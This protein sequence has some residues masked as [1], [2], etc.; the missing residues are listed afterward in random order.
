MAVAVE[1]EIKGVQFSNCNCAYACPCQF[2]GYPDK[3]HCEAVGAYHVDQG[4]YGDVRLD[5]LTAVGIYKWPG[6]VHEGNGAMQLVIDERADAGQRDAL[7]KILSGE[8]TEEAATMWWVFSMMSPTKHPPIFRPIDFSVDVEARRASVDIP[9]VAV[10]RGAPI[11]NP[12][13]GGE[14][15]VRIDFPTSFEFRLAEIG[16]GV[17]QT[18]GP[19]ALD[20]KDSYGQFAPMHLSHKGRLD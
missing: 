17:T 16:S 15:R 11:R 12:R 9:G 18:T 19:I 5:G 1:W 8:D 20:L 14:H 2:N 6:A 10:M 3:G 7:V 13:T 4:H